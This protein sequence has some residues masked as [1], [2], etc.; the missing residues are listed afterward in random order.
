MEP[1]L[2]LGSALVVNVGVGV[3]DGVA[4]GVADAVP[5]AMVTSTVPGRMDWTVTPCSA[6]M[7]AGINWYVPTVRPV[8]ST[9]T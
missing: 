8:R 3:G 7:T 4:V 5:L 1:A 9:R 2:A 6:T